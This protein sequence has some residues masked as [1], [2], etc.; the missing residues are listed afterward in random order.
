MRTYYLIKNISN[1]ELKDSKQMRSLYSKSIKSSDQ[2]IDTA[3][4]Q[5]R[6]VPTDPE[7]CRLR[8]V[9]TD[10]CASSRNSSTD[11]KESSTLRLYIT[12]EF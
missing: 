4:K 6:L 3:T 2:W 7:H 5:K 8:N 11:D 1:L 9:C 10:V 12:V